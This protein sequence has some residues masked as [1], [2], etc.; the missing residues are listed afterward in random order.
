VIYLITQ[1]DAGSPSTPATNFIN[2]FNSSANNTFSAIGIAIGT[3]TNVTLLSG[4]YEG[5][6][7]INDVKASTRT[8]TVNSPKYSSISMTISNSQLTGG[9]GAIYWG[10]SSS[11]TSTPSVE[12]LFNCQDGSGGN[13]LDCRREVFADNQV[14][15]ISNI[16]WLRSPVQCNWLHDIQCLLCA[17]QRLPIPADQHIHYHNANRDRVSHVELPNDRHDRINAGCAVDVMIY[18]T[19]KITSYNSL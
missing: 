15:L 14:H 9:N 11:S 12:Q 4:V 10:L 1:D 2:L 16:D 13:L 8:V 5:S 18:S 17:N 7:N 19:D 6:V 3:A